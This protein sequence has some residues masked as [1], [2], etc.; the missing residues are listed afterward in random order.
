MAKI[1]DNKPTIIE[2]S[3]KA[4]DSYGIEK[5]F[6]FYSLEEFQKWIKNPLLNNGR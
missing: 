6:Y 1:V 4:M 5:E 3:V 2:I